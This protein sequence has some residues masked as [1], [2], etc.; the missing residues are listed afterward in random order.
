MKPIN[1]MTIQECNEC[2]AVHMF[3]MYYHN[4]PDDSNTGWHSLDGSE[5]FREVP[6]YTHPDNVWQVVD[7]LL[8]PINGKYTVHEVKISA[9][10]ATI[11]FACIN[12]DETIVEEYIEEYGET[13]AEAL[14]RAAVEYCR[15]CDK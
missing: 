3:G 4:C 2:L 8:E 12:D 6:D 10:E 15:R 7:K 5:C 11:G 9:N 1:E 14:V 13:S